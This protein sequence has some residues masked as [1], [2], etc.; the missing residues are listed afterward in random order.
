MSV[1]AFARRG[2]YITG[3]ECR[4]RFIVPTLGTSKRAASIS[5]EIEDHDAAVGAWLVR[6]G[7]P[8]RLVDIHGQLKPRPVILMAGS[9]LRFPASNLIDDE[10]R[11]HLRSTFAEPVGFQMDA[12]IVI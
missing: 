9:F 3:G 12:T 10:G 11:K 1:P 5:S 8:G 7:L 6:R 2:A 4:P